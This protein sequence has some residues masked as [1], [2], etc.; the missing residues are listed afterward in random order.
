MIKLVHSRDARV[1]QQMQVNECKQHINGVKDKN[2]TIISID[3]EKATEK[4]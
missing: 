1:V 4:I 3:A 2:H